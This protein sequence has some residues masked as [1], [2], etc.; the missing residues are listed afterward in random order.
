VNILTSDQVDIAERFTGKGGLKGAASR[1][2]FFPQA[3]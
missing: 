2:A 1:L 3:I